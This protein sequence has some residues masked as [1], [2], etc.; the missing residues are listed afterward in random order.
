MS[1]EGGMPGLPDF[2]ALLQ[3]ASSMQEQ[4][5]AAQDELS[6]TRVD[7]S[8]G[9]GVVKATVSGTGE[10]LG[11]EIDPSVCDPDDTETLADLVL[12]AVHNAVENAQLQ[13]AN[14]MGDVASGFGGGLE[15]LLGFG[16]PPAADGDE[17]PRLPPTLP[18]A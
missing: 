16:A 2:E 12:A 5:M 9:G 7:G 13:A 8:S 3:Q 4:L 14:A 15:S 18:G 17:P 10:L 6:D 11:L 1:I